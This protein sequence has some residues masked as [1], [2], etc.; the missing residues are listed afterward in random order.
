MAI[1]LKSFYASVEC[2]DR[3]LDPMETCLVVADESR[4]EKTICLAVSPALKEFGVP[5]R[6][7]L[8]EVVARTKAVN[9][10]RLRGAPGRQF[11]GSS[12]LRS[13]LRDDP[14]LA[15]DY[16]V[17]PPRMK[18]YMEV[19]ADIFRRYLHWVSPEDLHVYSI[20][21]VFIDVTRYLRLYGISGRELAERMIHDV[22]H[23][24]GITA[25]AGIG[26][27]LYLAK[28][29]MDILAKHA[30]ADAHGVRIADLNERSYRERLWTHRPLT[31]FWRVGK[32]TA[33][34]LENMGLRT[35]GDVARCSLGE[36]YDRFNEDLLYKT[37]GVGAELLIDHAW[38]WEPITIAD[39][40]ACKPTRKS[41]SSGQVLPRPYAFT[42][43]RIVVQEMTDQLSLDLV[44]KGFLTDQL[45]LTV[46][47]D[48]ENLTN[49]GISFVGETKKDGYGRLIPRDAHGT[50]NL[51]AST[52]S[53]R[54]LVEAVTRLFDR[55]VNPELTIRRMYVYAARLR[56]EI[57][58]VSEPANP[59]TSGEQLDLFTDY[60]AEA[61]AKAAS[62]QALATERRNQEAILD[63]KHKFGKNAIFRGTNLQ[64]GATALQRNQ[65]S[66]G[67]HL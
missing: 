21:E 16:L 60:E 25:T 56:P 20:D 44:E 12:N 38:G 65:T 23:R 17:A 33:L 63:I 26:S 32:A 14:T 7:R 2:R 31:D 48:V 15:L 58:A 53:T 3:G 67:H 36:P 29:A 22:F 35:M 50:E 5:G 28:V 61:A 18:R 27:N 11:R 19:S 40:K 24:T 37:F 52:S 55:I 10:Q 64:E 1:D 46:G 59:E 57:D 34:K 30:P 45:V 51:E 66:G 43:A 6:P 42:E 8:F 41:L 49:P 9:Q 62:S 13:L 54:L 47:Y 39:I 4:T